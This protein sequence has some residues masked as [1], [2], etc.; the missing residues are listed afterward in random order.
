MTPRTYELHWTRLTIGFLNA[1]KGD[2]K[3]ILP[4]AY[5]E[6]YLRFRPSK[7]EEWNQ[8]RTTR[9][10]IDSPNPQV[11]WWEVVKAVID[12]VLRDSIVPSETPLVTGGVVSRFGEEEMAAAADGAATRAGPKAKRASSKR[13]I[14][15]GMSIDGDPKIKCELVNGR[16]IDSGEFVLEEAGTRGARSQWWLRPPKG[17]HQGTFFTATLH[18]PCPDDLLP[19][20]IE[21][22]T[23]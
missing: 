14:A 16:W 18:Y 4:D 10:V 23:S 15:A 11:R 17:L 20:P 19:T 8:P 3:N 6:M 13:G 9:V 7:M 2:D 21:P 12:T 5:R 1:G 22:A